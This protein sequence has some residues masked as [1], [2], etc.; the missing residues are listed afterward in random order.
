MALDDVYTC[1]RL[2]INFF[3]PGLKLVGKSRHGAKVRKVYDIS[4]T[5]HLRLL[6]SEVLRELKKRE[7]ATIYAA[8]N[9]VM[10]LKQIRQGVEHLWTLAEPSS[11]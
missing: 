4:Q 6:K 7:L 5:P 10:L 9:P 11:R 2:Y 3:Q 8:V 1:L